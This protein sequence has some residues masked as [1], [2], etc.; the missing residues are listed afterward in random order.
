MDRMI[1]D[2]C[3]KYLEKKYTWLYNNS[4]S[5]NNASN[6][7]AP[8]W[9]NVELHDLGVINSITR[10][11]TAGLVTDPEIGILFYIIPY[12]KSH[13]IKSKVANALSIRS[14]LLPDSNYNPSSEITDEAGAW[15]VTLCWLLEMPDKNEWLNSI[16]ELRKDTAYLEEIPVDFIVRK[17]GECWVSAFEAYAFPRLLFQTRKTLH[18]TNKEDALK[19]LSADASVKEAL[20][21]FTKRFIEHDQTVYARDVQERAMRYEPESEYDKSIVSPHIKTLNSLNVRNFR[22]IQNI[23][24]KLPL[25]ETGAMI[26]HGPNGTGKS[27]LFEALSLSLYQTSHRYNDFLKDKDIQVQNKTNKY[28]QEYL[29]PLEEDH[30]TSINPEIKINDKKIDLNLLDDIEKSMAHLRHMNGSFISQETSSNF[31]LLSSSEL[32]AEVLGGYSDLANNLR[33]YIQS[34]LDEANIKRQ[35]FLRRYGLN[36]II[37]NIKTAKNKIVDKIIRDEIPRVSYALLE[38]IANITNITVDPIPEVNTLYKQWTSWDESVKPAKEAEK[39]TSIEDIK[40][41]IFAHLNEYNMLY[42]KTNTFLKNFKNDYIADIDDHEKII[43]SINKWGKWLESHKEEEK[44]TDKEEILQIEREI[45]QLK[46]REEAIIVNGKLFRSRLDNYKNIEIILDSW[47]KLRPNECITCGTDLSDRDGLI[48]VINKLRENAKKERELLLKENEEITG[49]ITVLQKKHE[50]LKQ[51]THPLSLEER[52]SVMKPFMWFL[53]DE[54]AFAEYIKTEEK[55]TKLISFFRRIIQIPKI[56]GSLDARDE[57]ARIAEKI[58]SA[59]K[60]YQEVSKAPDDWD[61]VKKAFMEKAGDIVKKHLPNHLGALWRELTINL[62]PA[63]WLLPGQPTF[64][65]KTQ[66]RGHLISVGIE[67]GQL[68]RYLLNQAEIHTLGLSWFITRY[69]THGRFYHNFFVMDDP[70]Q[71]M[72]QATYRDLC[73]LWETLIRIHKKYDIPLAMLIMLHQ[74]SRALDAAR[75]TN[76]RLYILG[77]DKQ[78]EESTKRVTIRK[79][80]LIGDGFKPVKPKKVLR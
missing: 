33:D 62:T 75:A 59:F 48:R 47:I 64:L 50:L 38:W 18:M 65:V 36:I 45:K 30:S 29:T 35:E 17:E 26:I 71:E 69:L 32:A 57:T 66:T 54:E 40:K 73:R 4:F 24:I 10:D 49:K 53:K 27:S 52:R 72:D 9:H 51:I 19:W 31:S 58:M 22:N 34:R 78:Q 41:I 5:F 7:N 79:V 60:E 43:E 16:S 37:K 13:D 77:W 23:E 70:A 44:A 25:K 3:K 12:E 1:L 14:A 21:D 63:P 46:K 28:I 68:A 20:I 56:M 61:Q 15:R 67:Q 11:L 76:G 6:I 74:E 39:A 8:K 55:R 80:K 2:E 42:Q